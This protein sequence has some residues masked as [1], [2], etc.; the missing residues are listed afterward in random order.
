MTSTLNASRNVLASLLSQC[1]DSVADHVLWVDHNGQVHLDPLDRGVTANSFAVLNEAEMKFRLD[2]F[3]R[4]EGYVGPE[5]SK[6]AIWINRL[7]VAIERLWANDT[8]GLVKSF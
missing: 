1:D 8:K 3:Q 6:D 7:F 4:G 2:T 5:A